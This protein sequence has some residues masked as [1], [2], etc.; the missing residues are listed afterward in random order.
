MT[1]PLPHPSASSVAVTS[2]HTSSRG[3][4]SGAHQQQIQCEKLLAVVAESR[5]PPLQHPILLIFAQYQLRPWPP[6]CQLIL[7]GLGRL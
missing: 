1:V 5:A 4:L 7:I 6:P 2:G 3:M